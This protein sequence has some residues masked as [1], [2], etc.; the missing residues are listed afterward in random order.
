[1]SLEAGQFP[2]N[3][4]IKLVNGTRGSTVKVKKVIIFLLK[5]LEHPKR[6]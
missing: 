4:K 5:L 6:K 3:A 1:M 2:L